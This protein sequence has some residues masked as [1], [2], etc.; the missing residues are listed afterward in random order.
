MEGHTVS[1]Y[2][3]S[4]VRKVL[5]PFHRWRNQFQPLRLLLRSTCEMRRSRVYNYVNLSAIRMQIKIICGV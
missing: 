2:I 5:L 1:L 4:P 3:H